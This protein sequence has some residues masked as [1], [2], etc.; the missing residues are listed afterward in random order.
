MNCLT[1]QVSADRTFC[2]QLGSRCCCQV[3]PSSSS[4][5]LPGPEPRNELDNNPP[6]CLTVGVQCVGQ[7]TSTRHSGAAEVLCRPEGDCAA[8]DQI[9]FPS[10]LNTLWQQNKNPI[11]ESFIQFLP[12]LPGGEGKARCGGPDCIVSPSILGCT[13][14]QAPFYPCNNRL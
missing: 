6:H 3:R 8:A 9:D 5:P 14:A 4:Y 10:S 13:S 7:T 11:L 1:P 2:A 12:V